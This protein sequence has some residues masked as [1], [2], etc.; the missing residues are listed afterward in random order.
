M[1][2]ELNVTITAFLDE[3]SDADTEDAYLMAGAE[4]E[5]REPDVV[6]TTA[7]PQLFVQTAIYWSVSESRMRRRGRP[8]MGDVLFTLNSTMALLQSCR[9]NA[10]LCVLV[11]STLFHYISTRLFNKLVAEP[12]RYCSV[13]IG[14]KLGKRIDRIIAWAET[15][16]MELPAQEHLVVILQVSDPADEG[17]W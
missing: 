4:G 17:V 12:G 8:T 11:C 7:Q 3:T 16:G 9:V 10:T 6:P 14:M 15:Q 2:K 13:N 5:A 1:L